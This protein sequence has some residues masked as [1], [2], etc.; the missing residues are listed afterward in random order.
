MWGQFLKE[1]STTR[2]RYSGWAFIFH[3]GAENGLKN[4]PIDSSL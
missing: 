3:V 4:C 2:L 1:A